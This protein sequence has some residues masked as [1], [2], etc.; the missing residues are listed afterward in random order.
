MTSHIKTE[1][2]I[3]VHIQVTVIIEIIPPTVNMGTGLSILVSY[4]K[5]VWFLASDPSV[6]LCSAA[7]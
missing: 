1:I 5:K 4:R 2:E 3:L 6:A 7:A